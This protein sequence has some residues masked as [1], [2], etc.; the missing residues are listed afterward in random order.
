LWNNSPASGSKAQRLFAFFYYGART[1]ALAQFVATIH[2][3][4]FGAIVK[5]IRYTLLTVLLTLCAA[6]PATAEEPPRKDVE[7]AR[8][9]QV[10]QTELRREYAE[11]SNK[12]RN[13]RLQLSVQDKE[14]VA[15]KKQIA[16]LNASILERIAADKEF[17]ELSALHAELRKGMQAAF[18]KNRQVRQ[19]TRALVPAQQAPKSR[20]A[21]QAPAPPPP[22]PAKVSVK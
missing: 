3:R 19:T 17:G 14:I 10:T 1:R 5:S 12:L 7:G 15:M 6:L 20:P 22:P 18:Y 11:V 4:A 9:E 2:Q 16:E 13:R 21:A 8:K